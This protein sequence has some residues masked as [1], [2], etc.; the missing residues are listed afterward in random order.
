MA[1]LVRNILVFFL[2]L[3]SAFL[4]G[5]FYH[6]DHRLPEMSYNQFIQDLQSGFVSSITI[7]G[8]R[9]TVIPDGRDHYQIQVPDPQALM[10]RV[11]RSGVDISFAADLRHCSFPWS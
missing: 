10:D 9:V 8:T 5:L 4:L 11:A 1:V 6:L 3:F 7:T 2:A